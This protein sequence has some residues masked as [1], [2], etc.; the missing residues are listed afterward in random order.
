MESLLG[1]ITGIDYAANSGTYH[2][3]AKASTLHVCSQETHIR[4]LVSEIYAK[5]YRPNKSVKVI[6]R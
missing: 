3:E 6:L 1:E 4:T 5:R 2:A